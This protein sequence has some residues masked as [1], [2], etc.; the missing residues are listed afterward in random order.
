MDNRYVIGAMLAF[1]CSGRPAGSAEPKG[2]AGGKIGSLD[3]SSTSFTAN[4]AIPQKLTCEGDDTSPALAWSG[5]PAGT[6][7]FAVIVDDPDAPNGDWVHWVIYDVPASTT[8][9]SEGAAPPSG[10][11]SGVNGW[12]APGYKG[13]CPP[14]GTHHYHHKVYALDTVLPDLGTPSKAKLEKAMDGHVLAK[15]DLVGTY[16][17]R[18]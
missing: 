13:P 18:S 10:T 8:S 15:G 9:L 2:A 3:V 5:V 14:S 17:K 4:A 1:A 11:K 12:N 7:S 6:K 16:R